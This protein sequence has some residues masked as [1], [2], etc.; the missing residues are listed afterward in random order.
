MMNDEI[1]WNLQQELQR[2]LEAKY[3]GDIE[4]FEL[5]LKDILKLLGK[6]DL[7]TAEYTKDKDELFNSLFKKMETLVKSERNENTTQ[8]MT[9]SLN[10]FI[11][12][13]NGL[14]M[15]YMQ[16]VSG[17]IIEYVRSAK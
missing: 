2:L 16:D 11:E 15:K 4:M 7:D 1:R 17:F 6:D 3:K 9:N 10:A 13:Y 8:A 14:S 5:V 12:A